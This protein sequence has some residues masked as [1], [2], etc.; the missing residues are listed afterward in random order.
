VN[1]TRGV[2]HNPFRKNSGLLSP[3]EVLLGRMALS[4]RLVET[5]RKLFTEMYTLWATGVKVFTCG[6]LK[7]LSMM[8]QHTSVPPSPLR[9]TPQLKSLPPFQT[10]PPYSLY[11]C[12]KLSL[13]SLCLSQD[14][15][16]GRRAVCLSR[17]L[18]HLP[19]A[20]RQRTSR[21]RPGRCPRNKVGLLKSLFW[22]RSDSLV[23]SA[24]SSALA[25]SV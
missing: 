23:I 20:A 12:F 9:A 2:A 24:L 14:W 6:A 17:R 25:R 8:L 11:Y 18:S 10:C 22:L 13:R 1:F 16:L 5:H 15:A 7:W 3:A 19:L 21:S 4:R